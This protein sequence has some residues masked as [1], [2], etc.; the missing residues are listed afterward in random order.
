[1]NPR[2][3][4]AS[5]KPFMTVGNASLIEPMLEKVD[6]L[7]FGGDLLHL[8]CAQGKKDIVELLVRKGADVLNP[9]ESVQGEENYRRAPYV[10]QAVASGDAAT[11]ATI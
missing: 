3:P 10:L 2:D 9:P 5:L 1:M 4:V 6:M 11:L 7:K 8:A